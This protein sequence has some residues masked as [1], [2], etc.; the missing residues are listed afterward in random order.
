MRIA[1]WL[2]L[3]ALQ[4]PPI[5]Q[6]PP[7]PSDDAAVHAEMERL[8]G[9]VELRQRAIDKLLFQASTGRGPTPT[10]VDSGIERLLTRSRDDGEKVHRDMLRILELAANHRHSGGGS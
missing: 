10:D 2:A 3:F 5:P 1:L 6:E 4:A 8:I 7:A 9:E